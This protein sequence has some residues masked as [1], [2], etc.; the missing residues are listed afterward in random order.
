MKILS[1][2]VRGLGKKAKRR[3]IREMIA[4]HRIEF[5]CLQEIKLETMEDGICKAVWGGQNFDWA[6]KEAEGRSGFILSI[7]NDEIFCKSSSWHIKCMLV[8]N[9]FWRNDGSR[10]C[11]LNIYAPCNLADKLVLWDNIR[12]VV[13]QFD[14]ACICVVG[15]F[16]SVRRV[17]E[18]VGRGD[19]GY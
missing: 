13:D 19:E 14:D 16:N 5:C 2:N 17:E 8:V 1:F 4:K 18:R 11:L 6:Y 7:W 10:C 3:E 12:L 15:D 9:G